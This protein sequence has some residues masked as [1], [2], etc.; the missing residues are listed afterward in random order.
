RAVDQRMDRRCAVTAFAAHHR[1]S[2]AG[3]CRELHLAVDRIGEMAGER[4]LAGAG[5]AEQP[6]NLR[7]A[8]GAGLCLAPGLD[9]HQR[10]ILLRRKFSH[11][12]SPNDP[13]SYRK[14]E[15]RTSLK[16]LIFH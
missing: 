13:P 4:G 1:R 3:K 14:N 6:E 12:I 9:G 11:Y 5:V 7:R 8:V 10:L 15:T 16:T 2:L